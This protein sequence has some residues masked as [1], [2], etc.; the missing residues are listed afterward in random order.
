MLRLSAFSCILLYVVFMYIRLSV[1]FFYTICW[2][3]QMSSERYLGFT[4]GTSHHTFNL[5]LVAWVIYSPSGQLVSTGG[6]CL[7]FAS[8]NVTEYRAVIDILWD[9]LSHGIT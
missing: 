3:L 9:A 5:A 7:G 2:L 8:N 4:D 1:L 6:T